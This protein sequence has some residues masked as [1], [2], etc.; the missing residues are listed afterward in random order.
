VWEVVFNAARPPIIPSGACFGVYASWLRPASKRLYYGKHERR[1][2][3]DEEDASRARK[4]RLA[5]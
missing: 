4:V 1:N 5:L 3:D 2:E